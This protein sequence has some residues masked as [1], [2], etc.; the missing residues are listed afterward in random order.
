MN[1][2]DIIRTPR[3]IELVS[4]PFKAELSKKESLS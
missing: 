1:K 3:I 2:C 4:S